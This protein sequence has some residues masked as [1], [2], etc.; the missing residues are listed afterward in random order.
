MLE[1]IVDK[2]KERV[3]QSKKNKSLE[4]L[5]EE[6][7]QLEIT[8]DFPFKKA[9]SENE[10]SI[11]AEVKRAS[12]SKGLI[13]EDFDYVNIAKEYENAGA[14]AISVLTE[15]YF[16]K[17]S[18][19]YLKEIA[20]NVNIPILRKDFV[21]DEYMIWEAKLLGA[22]CVLLIV[23]I[24][25]IVELKKFLDLAHDLGLSAIVETHDG[26]EIRTALNVG[27]E[28][29]GVNNR[30]LNDFTVDIENSI[31]LRRCVSGDVIFISE[32]GIKTPEDVRKLKENDVDA[33][34]IGETLMKC[35]DKKAMILELKN[36]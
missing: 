10:I 28:I 3:S 15:P 31:S 33:V 11:I 5:K 29:I 16:F 14:S 23:S 20:Q 2:T 1:E 35:D 7:K 25:S 26:D 12:P 21:I 24:L 27:A 19:D 30:N 34:L 36:G 9:L 6:V 32:S 17:G 4:E 22:S 8:Q 13:A 18:D